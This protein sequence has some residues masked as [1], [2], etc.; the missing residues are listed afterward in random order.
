MGFRE[1]RA[2]GTWQILRG[3]TPAATATSVA[4]HVFPPKHRASDVRRWPT[5]SPSVT[6]HCVLRGRE[7]RGVRRDGGRREG[8]EKEGGREEGRNDGG[9][10]DRGEVGIHI[11]FKGNFEFLDTAKDKLMVTCVL[12]H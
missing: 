9:E 10:R 8:E 5:L 11:T 12:I 7:V 3:A 6:W 1:S 4:V 2:W